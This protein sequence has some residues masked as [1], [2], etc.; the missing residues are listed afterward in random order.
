MTDLIMH[1]V[2]QDNMKPFYEDRE[3]ERENKKW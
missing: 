2:V 1:S 3:K